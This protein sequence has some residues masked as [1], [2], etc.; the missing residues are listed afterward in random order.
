MSGYEVLR[1]QLAKESK[2]VASDSM[3]V[4]EEFEKFEENLPGET[5]EEL[6]KRAVV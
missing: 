2:I 5:Y 1:I 3:M 6:S 4:L